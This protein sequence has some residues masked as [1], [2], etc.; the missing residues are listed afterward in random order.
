MEFPPGGHEA[1][2]ALWLQVNAYMVTKPGYRW[3]RLHRR[4]DA[5]APFGLINLVE[6]ESASAWEAAH[7]AGFRERAVRP[8]M[9]FVAYPTVCVPV[10]SPDVMSAPGE[11]ASA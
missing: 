4:V 6:W 5:S 10:T 2:F 1:A 9:P 3:H 7:D 11:P 8:Q